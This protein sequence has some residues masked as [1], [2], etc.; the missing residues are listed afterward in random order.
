MAYENPSQSSSARRSL[1]INDRLDD[2]SVDQD[3][4]F[5]SPG[6]PRE[7]ARFLEEDVGEM[8]PMDDDEESLSDQEPMQGN[9][10]KAP[11]PVSTPT[12]MMMKF[13]Y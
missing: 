4:A 13:W 5:G 1:A 8:Q 2:E 12:A 10:E 11:P 3:A 7:T 6:V 9:E